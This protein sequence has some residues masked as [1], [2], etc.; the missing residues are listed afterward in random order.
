MDKRI[1]GRIFQQ[2][3]THFRSKYDVLGTVL[4]AHGITEVTK[5]ECFLSRNSQLNGV[6]RQIINISNRKKTKGRLPTEALNKRIL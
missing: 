5:A 2:R 3:K 1:S 4:S 6:E